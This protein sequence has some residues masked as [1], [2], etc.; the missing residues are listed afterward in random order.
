MEL[1]SAV[2]HA[3]CICP[4]VRTL[5]LDALIKFSKEHWE[6][7]SE[8]V[9]KKQ[10][11]ALANSEWNKMNDGHGWVAWI[12]HA[13]QQAVPAVHNVKEEWNLLAAY[14]LY[15]G[16]LLKVPDLV[17]MRG[18]P[19]RDK[20]DIWVKRLDHYRVACMKLL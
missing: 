7:W 6:K 3:V 5:G 13:V 14:E 2:F 4:L 18:E 9:G 20:P 16:T 19:E 15:T 8:H 12:Q 1:P 17:F 10:V 11:Q